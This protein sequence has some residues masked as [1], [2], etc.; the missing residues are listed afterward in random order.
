MRTPVE[1]RTCVSDP[2]DV[3][4]G[5]V[6]LSQTDVD[7]PGVLALTLRR[8]HVSSY[9][10]GGIF[11]P[12]WAST[13]DQ[14]VETDE[15]G[16]CFV[17]ED[18]SILYYPTATGTDEVM[19]SFGPRRWPLRRLASG[20]TVEDPDAGIIRTF[21]GPDPGGV[22]RID[23]IADRFGNWV[24]FCYDRDGPGRAGGGALRWLPGP[25]RYPRRPHPHAV[26][27]FPRHDSPDHRGRVRN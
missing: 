14:R 12:S 17:A 23:E 9:R 1:R 24:R 10:W 8:T 16:A 26:P 18:G 6:V 7:L 2:V 22:A 21:A 25:G 4:T 11:G 5:E 13:L 19:P 3:V 27:R 15:H 20:F